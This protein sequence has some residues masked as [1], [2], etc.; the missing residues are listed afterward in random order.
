MNQLTQAI[1]ALALTIV[2]QGIFPRIILARI[3]LAQTAS[4]NSQYLVTGHGNG[5]LRIWN[6]ATG[7]NLRTIAAH[8]Q[9]INSLNCG[10][11]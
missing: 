8:S 7:E 6:L 9:W 4:P 11:R 1:A 3:I 10:L 5:K 2:T